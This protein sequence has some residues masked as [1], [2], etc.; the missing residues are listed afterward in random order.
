VSDEFYLGYREPHPACMYFA[1]S[2]LVIQCLWS[3][4]QQHCSALVLTGKLLDLQLALS[5]SKV[6][7]NWHTGSLATWG[8][9]LPFCFILKDIAVCAVSFEL[10]WK[11]GTRSFGGFWM[12]DVGCVVCFCCTL[13]WMCAYFKVLISNVTV[14]VIAS[15]DVASVGRCMHTHTHARLGV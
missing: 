10:G 7:F 13:C 8:V 12:L 14:F 4:H 5:S 9:L 1:C 15:R 2:I 6:N 3:Q 11:Y